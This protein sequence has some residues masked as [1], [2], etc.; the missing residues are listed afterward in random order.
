MSVAIHG[1]APPEDVDFIDVSDALH[2]TLNP[3]F[4]ISDPNP[5]IKVPRRAPSGTFESTSP[6]STTSALSA[7]GD[8]LDDKR[9]PTT[10]QG[11]TN[12]PEKIARPRN[13]FILFRCDYVAKHQREG[14]RV[15]RAPGTEAEK[16][17]SKQAA[18]AWHQLT[19]EERLYWKGCANRERNEHA[20]QYPHYRYRPKKS[21]AGRRRQ[22]RSSPTKGGAPGSPSKGDS[23]RPESVS[24][25]LTRESSVADFSTTTNRLRPRKST[26][27]PEFGIVDSTNRR[28]RSTASHGWIAMANNGGNRMNFGTSSRGY[29]SLAPS[30][31]GTPHYHSPQYSLSPTPLPAPGLVSSMSSSLLNWN[32]ERM[33]PTRP[34]PTQYL[35]STCVSSLPEMIVENEVMMSEYTSGGNPIPSSQLFAVD[36]THNNHYQGAEHDVWLPQLQNYN[37]P[38]DTVSVSQTASEGSASS[39]MLLLQSTHEDTYLPHPPPPAAAAP[40]AS[41]V[42]VNG[43]GV[44]TS[45]APVYD[46]L[47]QAHAPHMD[48]DMNSIPDDYL[49]GGD[50]A[51]AIDETPC[52]ENM[53][54]KGQDDIWSANY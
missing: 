9:T 42:N 43:N 16:T 50:G 48:Y 41:N 4:H 49:L 35:S 39:D 8:Y 13:E 14:K 28:L 36:S 2:P 52:P 38:E 40:P 53:F 51:G 17:L 31:T 54:T 7:D 15:R 45:L 6:A 23:S 3:T 32:G 29:N 11:K 37:G 12:D 26:S 30:A 24:P 10:A 5:V 46:A 22:T 21:A 44:S 1:W 47:G 27:V 20:R 33:V 19:P 25:S 18:E 34:Q